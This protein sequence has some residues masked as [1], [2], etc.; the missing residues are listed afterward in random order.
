VLL[1]ARLLL[2]PPF[3]MLKAKMTTTLARTEPRPAGAVAGGLMGW[4]L[5]YAEPEGSQQPV[6]GVVRTG[7]EMSLTACSVRLQPQNA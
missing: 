6:Q 4:L 1:I 2:L 5:T 3:R 7:S